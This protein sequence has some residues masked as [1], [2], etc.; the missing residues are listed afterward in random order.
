MMKEKLIKG[1][2]ITKVF[3]LL[4]YNSFN[5]QLAGM[6]EAG[7]QGRRRPTQILAE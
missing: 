5:K 7:G 6:A 4:G 1:R 3:F 2:N